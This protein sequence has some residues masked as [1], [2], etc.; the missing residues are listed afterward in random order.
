MSRPIDIALEKVASDLERFLAEEGPAR[1]GAP[2]PGTAHQ[3]MTESPEYLLRDIRRMA[4]ESVSELRTQQAVFVANNRC[5]WG[6]ALDQ[7]CLFLQLTSEVGERFIKRSRSKRGDEADPVMLVLSRLLAKGIL[8]ARECH[9]LLENGFS[10]GAWMRWRTL[11]EV[12]ATGCFIKSRGNEAAKAFL[13]HEMIDAYHLASSYKEYEGR[14]RVPTPTDEDM[15]WL[16][17]RRDAVA[18]KHG[19]A[20]LRAY[21]WAEA[22]L[23]GERCAFVEIEKAAGLEHWRP[24]YIW[25]S[26]GVHAT[27]RGSRSP[28]AQPFNSDNQFLVGPSNSGLS[29]PGQC[30]AISVTHLTT[31]LILNSPD[32]EG[33]VELKV[34]DTLMEEV[35]D[36]FFSASA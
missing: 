23:D 8:I 22:F 19:R 1:P 27:G 29:D 14:L 36:A 16:K 17:D 11:H 33:L 35:T 21:G 13:D 6:A 7:L 30:I 12:A 18:K 4:A 3:V 34:L 26:Q 5:H 2:P 15:K 32:L 31:A 24:F 10:D 20:F 9:C 25:A 28:L